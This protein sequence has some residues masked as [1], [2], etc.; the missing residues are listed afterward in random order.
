MVAFAVVV[1]HAAG[2]ASAE[3]ASAVLAPGVLA[4][5]VVASAVVASAVVAPTT[6]VQW[7]AWEQKEPKVGAV[8]MRLHVW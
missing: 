8:L 3:A 4:P 1:A 7:L 2:L 5:A 6:V